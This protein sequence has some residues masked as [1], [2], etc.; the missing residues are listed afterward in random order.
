MN[1][2]KLYVFLLMLVCLVA[3]TAFAALP[4]E[5]TYEKRSKSGAIEARMY[6]LAA[7][8]DSAYTTSLGNENSEVIWVECYLEDGRI[9][10]Q[11][12][13]NYIWKRDDV[14][15]AE[16]ALILDREESYCLEDNIPA[17][18]R[19]ARDMASF[20]FRDNGTA[21]VYVQKDFTGVPASWDL[22]D[23]SS[24]FNGE[25][26][27]ISPR[28]RFSPLVVAYANEKTG[29]VE[30]F[31]DANVNQDWNQARIRIEKAND[32]RYNIFENMMELGHLI[33][34]KARVG[35]DLAL[36]GETGRGV[37]IGTEVRF[38]STPFINDNNIL[39]FLNLDE[40]VTVHGLVEGYDG[41]NWCY[42]T[43]ANGQ[44]GFAAAQFIDV[45]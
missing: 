30:R 10:S 13:T 4:K 24:N 43:R 9:W 27:H 2:K 25:Y 45:R 20:S 31:N 18:P 14:G 44:N 42:F 5:G 19:Y 41:Q 3:N 36:V 21:T 26:K 12:A 33:V 37:L 11:F 16:T 17:T 39:G 7:G 35:N 32:G 1:I 29:K 6:V 38:R 28:V 40:N 15:A 23:V 22:A 34:M 8:N